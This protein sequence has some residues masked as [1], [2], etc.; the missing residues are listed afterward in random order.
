VWLTQYAPFFKAG[1]AVMG[2]A[3]GRGSGLARCFF[4]GEPVIP[5]GARKAAF[6]AVASGVVC[7]DSMPG[8]YSPARNSPFFFLFFWFFFLFLFFKKVLGGK[9][10]RATPGLTARNCAF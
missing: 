4:P 2:V 3:N 6:A 5:A 8:G 1:L 10:K 9:E 7:L